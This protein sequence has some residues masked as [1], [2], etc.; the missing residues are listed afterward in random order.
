VIE[1]FT[2][3]GCSACL[4]VDTALYEAAQRGHALLLSYHVDYWDDLGWRDPFSSAAATQRQARYVHTLGLRMAAT[5]Q[6]VLDGERSAMG[7]AIAPPMTVSRPEPVSLRMRL[8]GGQL[9]VDVGDVTHAHVADLLLLAVRDRA[10][11]RVGAGE[12]GGKTMVDHN[13]VL[14]TEAIGRWR[15][16]A[17]EL[18]VS[19][20]RLPA[21]ATQ[22]V[23]LLQEYGQGRILA[24]QCAAL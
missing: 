22:V 3:Q 5:P 16:H 8:S 7:R 10:E 24:A 4:E 1:L 17:M 13:V 11:T 18:S 20:S 6:W 19:R 2:S 15:G 23:V 12:N 14:G 21:Q 9:L